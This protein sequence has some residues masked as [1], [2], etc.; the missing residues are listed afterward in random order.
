LFHQ[1]VRMLFWI[2]DND[3]VV[4]GRI[5]LTGQSEKRVLDGINTNSTSVNSRFIIKMQSPLQD[6]RNQLCSYVLFEY[7]SDCAMWCAVKSYH[8]FDADS[9]I[10]NSFSSSKSDQWARSSSFHS[11]EH[12]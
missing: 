2:G 1:D 6:D 10:A 11:S 4:G 9:L 3:Y 7:P 5:E 12:L 8:I